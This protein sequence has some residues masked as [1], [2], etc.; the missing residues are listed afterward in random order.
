MRIKLD[1]TLCD[2]F[3]TCALHAPEVF[4]LDD[5]GYASLTGDGNIAPEQEAGVRRA[6]LD[7]PVHAIIELSE[8][9]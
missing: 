8:R 2:G 4:S 9:G 6:L 3:G 7:C 1:R 5:W